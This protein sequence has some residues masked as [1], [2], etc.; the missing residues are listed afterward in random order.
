MGKRKHPPLDCRQVKRILKTL[1]FAPRPVKGGGS[2]HEQWV[3]DNPFR[4]VTVDCPKEPFDH[5]LIHSMAR[6]AGVS[7]D[8]FYAALDKKK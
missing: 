6:Q 8:D 5:D 1:G 3:K 7:V 4:K 2:S